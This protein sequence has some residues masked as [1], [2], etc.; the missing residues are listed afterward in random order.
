MNDLLKVCFV[1]AA[2][3][4]LASQAGAVTVPSFT[5]TYDEATGVE[6]GGDFDN[7]GANLGAPTEVGDFNLVAGT[8]TFLGSIGTPS[9]PADV[10]NI[11]IG[12]NQTLI[13]ATLTFGDNVDAFNPYFGF[14]S[15]KWG[16][17]ES[18]VTPVIFEY[19]VPDSNGTTAS[20]SSTQTFT[21]GP[22][23]YNM[24]FG[25]GVFGTNNGAV[26]YT[27]TFTVLEV[28]PPPPPPAAVPLPAGGLLLLTG[29]G[30]LM[31]ARRKRST[32]A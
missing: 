31:L 15:P 21:R 32:R 19:Q 6:A 18:S 11:V 25:N 12:T 14:P 2:S 27:M 8:N 1:A 17:Y 23:T 10:F 5:G 22:G 13:G 20:F 29:F 30:G 16:L 3:L 26:D 28:T 7:I 4:G 9:D 24:L